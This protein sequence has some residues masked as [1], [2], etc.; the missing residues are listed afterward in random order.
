MAY[1][2]YN[3]VL[4]R[5]TDSEDLPATEA[6]VETLLGDAED[7]I[8]REFPTLHDRVTSGELPERRVVMVEVDMVTRRLRNPGGVRSA[9]QGA[10]AYQQTITYGGDEPG[11]LYLS[12]EERRLLSGASSK[13]KAFSIDTTP[14]YYSTSSDCDLWWSP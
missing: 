1:A 6:Q 10:G 14:A 9:Q 11:S 3:D 2:E 4:S 7:I 13:N 12:D 5:W 8:E